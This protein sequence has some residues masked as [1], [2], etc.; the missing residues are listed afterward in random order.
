MLIE[1]GR[2]NSKPH[3]HAVKIS[4]NGLNKIYRK[5]IFKSVA[6]IS[7]GCQLMQRAWL[8][9]GGRH[10]SDISIHLVER[11]DSFISGDMSKPCLKRP[12]LPVGTL[13]AIENAA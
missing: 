13:L 12:R 5:K 9:S 11:T 2:V 3:L 7:S 6:E 1:T 8:C 4:T 10:H